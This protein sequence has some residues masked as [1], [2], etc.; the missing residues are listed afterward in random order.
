[1][2][3]FES[4]QKDES[5]AQ[6]VD[7]SQAYRKP[8]RAFNCQ[9]RLSEFFHLKNGLIG[10]WNIFTAP[11]NVTGTTSCRTAPKNFKTKNTQLKKSKMHKNPQRMVSSLTL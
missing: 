6:S 11:N 5:R 3:K 8:S 4:S 1:M 9:S 7:S 2:R 10:I